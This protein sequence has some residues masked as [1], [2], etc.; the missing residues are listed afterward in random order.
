M[1]T[2]SLT[3]DLLEAGIDE[4][5]RGCLAGEVVA[6]AVILPKDYTHTWLTDSK[7]LSKKQREELRLEIEKEAISIGVGTAS[8]QEIDKINILQATI[9]AMHRAIALLSPQP[10]L[11]LIDGNYFKPYDLITHQCVVKGDSLFLS[12]AAASIVAKTERDKLMENYAQKYPNYFWANNAGYAT[13]AHY[14]AI[15]RYGITPLHR[16]SFRL[17]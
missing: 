10:E 9:L 13:K 1:L 6:A 5:G 17:V 4:A 12:I 14:E 15:K 2:S 11:L 8:P 16:K 7:K 3:P